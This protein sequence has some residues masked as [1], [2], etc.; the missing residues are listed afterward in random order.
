[1]FAAMLLAVLQD[2]AGYNGFDQSSYME[3]R[4]AE[5]K[6]AESYV[7]PSGTLVS[8]PKELVGEWHV[9]SGFEGTAVTFAEPVRGEMYVKFE[10]GG[11]LSMWTLHR[12]AT[13]KD[14]VVQLNRAVEAYCRGPY[15]RWFLVK[16]NDVLS[17]VPAG[18]VE[19]NRGGWSEFHALRKRPAKARA[20]D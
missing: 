8:D 11:C 15:D 17:L 9:S 14:G 6:P 10:T 12:T 7:V 3:K 2:P 19:K 13:L 18:T 4:L 20:V 1:M 16:S 5:W